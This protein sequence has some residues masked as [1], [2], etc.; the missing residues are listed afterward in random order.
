MV[1]QWRQA[2]AGDAAA[3]KSQCI[4]LA[5]AIVAKWG[6]NHYGRVDP[7]EQK[8]GEQLLKALAEL[9]DPGLIGDFLG[10]VLIEDVSVEPSK[11]LVTLG[12]KY[13]WGTFQPQLLAVMKGTTKGSLERNVR[14][15]EQI[16]TA[17]PRKKEGWGELCAALAQELVPAIETIDRGTSNDW[18]YRNVERAEVLAGLARALIATEQ[19]ELL[20]RFVAHALASPKTYPLKLA[21][22]PALEKLRPWLKTNVK[23]PIPALTQWVASCREQL[24]SLTAHAPQEPTDFR[25]TAAV[26]CNCADCAELKRFLHD[27]NEPMHRFSVKQ[28]RRTHLE[29]K[30]RE[31]QLDLNTTTERLR[32]PYTLVCTK[33]KASYQASL[34]TYLQDQ[35]HLATVRS[36]EA[37]LPGRSGSKV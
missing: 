15:L 30:I 5:T 3:L 19:S 18:N 24:E 36:I 13:G 27:P 7:L 6:Q 21:H 33:N 1:A 34:K 17:K 9:D 12:Q 31:H 14:L 28:E 2:G 25:R 11:S 10:D 8:A 37:S 35:E 26:A 22:L 23:K 4:E 29:G 20:S 16:A 32:S